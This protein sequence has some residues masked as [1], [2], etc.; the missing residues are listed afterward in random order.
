L[1]LDPGTAR[2]DRREREAPMGGLLLVV[3]EFLW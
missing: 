3:N 2:Q 1:G